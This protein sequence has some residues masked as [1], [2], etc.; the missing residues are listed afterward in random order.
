MAEK[1]QRG[2]T[3]MATA[4]DIKTGPQ[5]D[6]IEITDDLGGHWRYGRGDHARSAPAVHV[7]V[8]G[9]KPT[10]L[11]DG[12]GRPVLH[13]EEEGLPEKIIVR[14]EDPGSGSIPKGDYQYELVG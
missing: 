9:D 12:S 3:I 6:W 2:T 7:Q 5:W 13:L 10:L 1:L 4:K 8:K 14:F 11:K